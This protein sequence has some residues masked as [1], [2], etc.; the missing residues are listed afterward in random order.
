MMTKFIFLII[1]LMAVL[2]ASAI[3][4]L[5]LND[6]VEADAVNSAEWII[7][8][9][10]ANEKCCRECPKYIEEFGYCKY[11]FLSPHHWKDGEE[12][13]GISG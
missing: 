7:S 5:I 10:C 1:V 12:K 4:G 13:D 11:K 9:F 3:A 2:V 8:D 6:Y